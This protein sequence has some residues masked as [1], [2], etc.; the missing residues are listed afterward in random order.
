MNANLELRSLLERHWMA[1][2]QLVGK[3]TVARLLTEIESGNTNVETWAIK[4]A[5]GTPMDV[6][7]AI[8]ALSV[9]V[10]FLQLALRAR[11]E[12]AKR[13]KP[14]AGELKAQL[15]KLI[16]GANSPEEK[17]LASERG[18]KIIDELSR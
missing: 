15:S 5:G 2:C 3:E 9:A 1:Q 12:L 11:D 17:V 10:T 7:L 8:K 16:V 18:Q 6:E 13:K 14:D 4:K